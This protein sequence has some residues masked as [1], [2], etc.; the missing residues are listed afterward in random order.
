MHNIRSESQEYL[1][2]SICHF[3]SCL[4]EANLK[5]TKEIDISNKKLQA[6]LEQ[7]FVVDSLNLYTSVQRFLQYKHKKT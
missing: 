3:K 4:Y 1:V 5:I 7:Y 2:T 6:L